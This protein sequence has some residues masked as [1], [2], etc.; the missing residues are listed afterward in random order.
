[1]ASNSTRIINIALRGLT[2]LTRFL[3]IFFIAKHLEATDIGYYGLFTATVGYSIYFVGL[4]FY[5][6]TSR[7]ILKTTKNNQGALLKNQ[8]VLSSSLYAIFVPVSYALLIIYAEWPSSMLY[9]FLPILILEHFN[10][11]ISRLLT[12]LS[13]QLTASTVLFIRQGSWAIATIALLYL[14]PQTRNL[15]MLM[16][17]WCISGIGAAMIG[18]YKLRKLGIGGWSAPIN[19][20]WIRQGITVSS[21]FLVATLALRGIE[22][23]DRYWI[24]ALGGLDVVAAYTLFFGVT[25]ALLSFLD[26]GVFSFAYPALIKHAYEHDFKKLHEKTRQMLWITLLLSICFSIVSLLVIPHLLNWIGKESYAENIDI[27][28]WLLLSTSLNAIGLVP[29]YALYGCGRDKA[30]IHSHLAAFLVFVTATWLLSNLSGARAVPQGL[31]CAF[32]TILVWK[33]AA[34]YQ[35]ILPLFRNQ[36]SRISSGISE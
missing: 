23:F 25:G 2:L 13:L 27:Y 14:Q 29:H 34:Y 11:E 8:L 7:E 19:W 21:A 10:Q 9:W 24:E 22:T 33:A 4:D 16:L 31:V 12:A 17:L 26:A 3:F 36:T 1:M 6:Y 15:S 20:R 18:I 30:I 28:Y 32:L 35:S 5:T